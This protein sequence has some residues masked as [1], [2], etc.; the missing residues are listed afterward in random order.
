MEILG[1]WAFAETLPNNLWDSFLWSD[2]VKSYIAIIAKVYS[3]FTISIV[4]NCLNSL[5]F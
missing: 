1:F 2:F 3:D 5:Y 4:S